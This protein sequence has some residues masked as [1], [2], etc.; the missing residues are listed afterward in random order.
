[1]PEERTVYAVMHCI[2]YEGSSVIKAFVCKEAAERFQ[3]ACEAYEKT[4]RELPDHSD[5]GWYERLIAWEK[6]HPAGEF[7]SG[8]DRYSIREITLVA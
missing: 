7:G 4:K 5:D 2:D 6:G 8:A 1:M 3:Q